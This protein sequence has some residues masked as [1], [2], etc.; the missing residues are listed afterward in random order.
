[1]GFPKTHDLSGL[2]VLVLSVE[3]G[4]EDL[5]DPLDRLTGMGAE[6]R[7]PGGSADRPEATEAVATAGR[8]R[9]TIRACLGFS[10]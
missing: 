3:P 4:V 2:L 8:V 6:V 1:M 7:R 10:P 5:R 9:Q